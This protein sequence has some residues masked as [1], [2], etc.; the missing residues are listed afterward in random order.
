M[1]VKLHKLSLDNA[2]PPNILGHCNA[3]ELAPA[4]SIGWNND[5]LGAPNGKL[6]PGAMKNHGSKTVGRGHKSGLHIS[7]RTFA[8]VTAD[9]S[10]PPVDL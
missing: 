8:Q 4:A 3:A 10:V 6:P 7:V 2:I 5:F 9:A 1:P